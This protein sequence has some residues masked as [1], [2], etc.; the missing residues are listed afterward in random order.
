MLDLKNNLKICYNAGMSKTDKASVRK[1]GIKEI[2]GGV[3]IAAVGGIISAISYNSAKPGE[4]YT[5][6]TGIIALGVVYAFKGLY[7]VAFPAGFGKAKKDAEAA[8]AKKVEA[9]AEADIV[10]EEE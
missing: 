4:S 8:E 3:A 10:K 2:L 5:V 7:D 6:Y 9:S 1:R